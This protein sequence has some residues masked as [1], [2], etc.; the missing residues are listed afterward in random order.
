MRERFHDVMSMVFHDCTPVFL[1]GP[2]GI[3][4]EPCE[5]A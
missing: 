5:W 4:V 2:E 3:T 1:G